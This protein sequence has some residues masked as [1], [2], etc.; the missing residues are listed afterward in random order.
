MNRLPCFRG[1]GAQVKLS[2]HFKNLGLQ[3]SFNENKSLKLNFDLFIYF[4]LLKNIITRVLELR[5]SFLHWLR[6]KLIDNEQVTYTFN[7]KIVFESFTV[8]IDQTVTSAIQQKGSLD[9]KVVHF[10]AQS[11]FRQLE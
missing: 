6:N 8:C 2:S 10:V 11:H 7:R 1:A 3:K 5:P 4:H 9:L